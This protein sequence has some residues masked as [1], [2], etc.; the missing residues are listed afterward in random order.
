MRFGWPEKPKKAQR[1][2][3]P[4]NTLAG[5]SISGFLLC[6]LQLQRK[7]IVTQAPPYIRFGQDSVHESAGVMGWQG[8][9]QALTLHPVLT[10]VAAYTLSDAW[11]HCYSVW[12]VWMRA[13][14]Q[15]TPGS[16]QAS[17]QAGLM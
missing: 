5:C 12:Y 14:T 4:H 8:T 10:P 17:L 11:C 1:S 13:T 9:G 7:A 3:G 6:S 16:R 15:G 2:D